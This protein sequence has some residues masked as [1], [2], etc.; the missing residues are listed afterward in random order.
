M[1]IGAPFEIKKEKKSK[2]QEDE[3]KQ[4]EIIHKSHSIGLLFHLAE[5]AVSHGSSWETK[6]SNSDIL[7]VSLR[8]DAT[9]LAYTTTRNKTSCHPARRDEEICGLAWSR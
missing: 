1:M 5:N 2:R 3:Q 4:N 7:L 9:D 6:H 8:V